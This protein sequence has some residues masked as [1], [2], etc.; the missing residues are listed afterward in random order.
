MK[1]KLKDDDVLERAIG[2]IPRIAQIIVGMPPTKNI[3]RWTW[4]NIATVELHGNWVSAKVKLVDGH[5]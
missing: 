5:P 3:G 4:S 1:S 2:G